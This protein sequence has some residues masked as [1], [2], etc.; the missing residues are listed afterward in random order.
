MFR[1]R[2]KDFDQ[3]WREYNLAEGMPAWEAAKKQR[4]LIRALEHA[5]VLSGLLPK[6]IT[7]IQQPS[8]RDKPG[9]RGKNRNKITGMMAPAQREKHRARR[10]E[11]KTDPRMLITV[12]A[13]SPWG[14]YVGQDD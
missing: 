12:L 2:A 6:R 4:Q 13:G 14:A 9:R 10:M 8:W 1:A 3:G 5:V 11:G 7:G